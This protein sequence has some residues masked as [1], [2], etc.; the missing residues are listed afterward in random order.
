MRLGPR[1][2]DFV[3][4]AV[5]KA[6][7]H[8]LQQEP[9][10][11]RYVNLCFALGPNFE[12]KAENEWALALLSNDALVDWVTLHQLVVKACSVLQGMPVDG[13]RAAAQLQH[14]D[15]AFL[16]SYDALPRPD[17]EPAL[18]RVAC[19]IEMLDIGLLEQ[20][21]R[22]EYTL[23]NGQ[24]SRTSVTLTATA[25]RITAG[26]APPR[27]VT[28]LSHAPGNGPLARVQ[29]RQ[30]MHACC[31]Q[32]VHPALRLTGPHGLAHWQ[33]HPA[34]ALSWEAP[35]VAGVPAPSGLGAL[36]LVETQASISLLNAQCCGLRD[37]GVPTGTF[38]TWL[39]CYRADQYLFAFQRSA[40]LEAQWPRDPQAAPSVA[41]SSLGYERD[42]VPLPTHVWLEGLDQALPQQ[43]QQGLDH[44]FAQWAAGLQN[45]SMRTSVGLLQGQCDLTWG[46][47]ESALGLA[48]PAWMRVAGHIDLHNQLDLELSGELALGVT[49]TRL[50]LSLKGALPWVCSL[51][52]EPQA[53]LMQTVLAGGA[54]GQLPFQISFDPIAVEEG[55]MLSSVSG[56]TGQLGLECGLR[57]RTQGG[58]GWQFY[59]RLQTTPV[60]VSLTLHDPVLGHAHKSLVLLPASKLLDWS[61]G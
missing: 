13:P 54:R 22:H 43:L 10:V 41:L 17:E 16:D 18:A 50:Q 61:L 58:G 4:A 52:R 57:P 2:N 48:E 21:G 20:S 8:H 53:D 37:T 59:L 29:V 1:L 40:L 5:Q 51:Q 34:T 33:G 27:Q 38:E 39:W 15:A 11:A 47:R 55:A 6:G 14:A 36:L 32:D 26:Q 30:H 45:A 49:R 56:C 3:A 9:A 31:A 42:G 7:R 60:S 12:D 24:W 44:L 23:V 46:W 25:L 19:D 28:L 35:A